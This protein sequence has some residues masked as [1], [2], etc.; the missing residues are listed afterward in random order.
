VIEIIDYL[1]C[2]MVQRDAQCRAAY[3]AKDAARVERTRGVLK[4]RGGR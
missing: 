2:E 3:E 4:E 1:E